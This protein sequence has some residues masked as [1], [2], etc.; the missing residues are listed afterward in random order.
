MSTRLSRSASAG[1]MLLAL[2][3]MPQ[4]VDAQGRGNGRGKGEK[5]VQA[6]ATIGFSVELGTQIRE[7][8]VSHAT[9]A[10]KPLP[11]GMRNRLAQGKELPPGIAK[12]GLPP[13]LHAMLHVPPGYEV[14]EVGVDVLLVEIATSVVHDVLMDIVR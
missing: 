2:A 3:M 12:R 8:Y 7:Y 5:P 4:A 13:D 14:V 6:Q 1:M 10:A 11:P 9:G